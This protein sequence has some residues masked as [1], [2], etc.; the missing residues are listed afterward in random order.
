MDNRDKII[1]DLYELKSSISS[2][3]FELEN[4]RKQN[5]TALFKSCFAQFDEI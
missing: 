2:E 3:I 1:K 4:K 5:D